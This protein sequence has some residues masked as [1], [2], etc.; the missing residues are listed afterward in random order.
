VG[1]GHQTPAGTDDVV[2]PGPLAV[3]LHRRLEEEPARAR[4]T[5]KDDALGDG[6][7]RR[8]VGEASVVGRDEGLVAPPGLLRIGDADHLPISIASSMTARACGPRSSS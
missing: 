6:R 1:Q 5:G 4:R 3:A 8:H 2:E 7:E